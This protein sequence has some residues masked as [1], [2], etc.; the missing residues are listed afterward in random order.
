[1]KP[2]KNYWHT[3]NE[4]SQ[5]MLYMNSDNNSERKDNIQGDSVSS[6]SSGTQYAL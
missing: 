5:E 6:S 1:M 4:E 3:R 2:I